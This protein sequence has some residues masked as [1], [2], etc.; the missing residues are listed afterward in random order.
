MINQCRVGFFYHQEGLYPHAHSNRPRKNNS[1]RKR[2]LI[3]WELEKH[4]QSL[5]GNMNCTP[6]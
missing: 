2:C 3:T 1:K 5:H 4:V 6:I